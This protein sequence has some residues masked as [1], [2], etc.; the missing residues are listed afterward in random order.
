MLEL[1]LRAWPEGISV[2]N[3]YK[4]TPTQVA[5]MGKRREATKLLVQAEEQMVAEVEAKLKAE[6][7]AEAAAAAAAVEA[8]AQA[9]AEADAEQA[10][11]ADKAVEAEEDVAEEVEVEE[12]D[13][14]ADVAAEAEEE[15]DADVAAASQAAVEEE[16][17]GDGDDDGHSAGDGC[18]NDDD[19]GVRSARWTRC[20]FPLR[21][22][23]SHQPMRWPAR[24]PDC[25][26]LQWCELEQLKEYLRVHKCCP[27]AGCTAKFHERR[28]AAVDGELLRLLATVGPPEPKHIWLWQPQAPHRD[29]WR[30]LPLQLRLDDPEPPD[31]HELRGAARKRRREGDDQPEAEPRVKCEKA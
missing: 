28:M 8:A 9:G 25:L 19:D 1:L 29:G 22:T 3:R 15:G 27:C 17:D 10:S 6:V 20:A 21:C 4:K 11:G 7:T 16:G 23:I 14:D 13:V 31:A 30:R 2:Q 18:G 24:G 26:H 12:A 5:R